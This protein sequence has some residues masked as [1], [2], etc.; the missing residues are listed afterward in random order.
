MINTASIHTF[1]KSNL[2]PPRL[3]TMCLCATEH[4]TRHMQFSGSSYV[5]IRFVYTNARRLGSGLD[6]TID[7]LNMSPPEI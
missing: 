7:F 3:F 2:L 6:T 4:T 5:Y 1:A